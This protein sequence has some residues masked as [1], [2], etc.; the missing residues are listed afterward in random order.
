MSPN[1]GGAILRALCAFWGW[2]L[3]W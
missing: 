2:S 1:G 3:Y